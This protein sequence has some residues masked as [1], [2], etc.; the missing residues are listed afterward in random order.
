MYH[1]FFAHSSV[2]VHL[3][4][5][6]VMDIVHSVAVNIC[7][8]VSFQI[9]GF[10]RYVLKSESA[11]SYGSSSFSFIR[12]LQTVVFSGCTNLHFHK[13]CKKVPFLSTLSSAF[14]ICNFFLTDGHSDRCE[15]IFHSSFDLCFSN[16][17]WCWASFHV[18]FSHL[19]V[20]F[21]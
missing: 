20:F 3:S 21:G 9:I 15:V 11:R 12:N 13:L 14:I 5:L 16:S 2:D 18:L 17:L 1:I 6:H 19:Y 4:C 7:V 10:S 8:H